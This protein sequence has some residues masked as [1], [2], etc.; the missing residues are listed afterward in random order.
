MDDC[1]IGGCTIVLADTGRMSHIDGLLDAKT[2]KGDD[3]AYRSEPSRA[4]G[5]AGLV[6]GLTRALLAGVCDPDLVAE[7]KS[8]GMRATLAVILSAPPWK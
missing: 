1:D 3:P 7:S 4:I 6:L 2:S 5:D 8:E